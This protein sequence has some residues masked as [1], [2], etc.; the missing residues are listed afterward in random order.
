MYKVNTGLLEDLHISH[1]Q[2][3][4]QRLILRS[5]LK[6]FFKPGTTRLHSIMSIIL[7]R[8]CSIIKLFSVAMEILNSRLK[9]NGY[10]VWYVLLMI[11]WVFNKTESAYIGSSTGL[12][13]LNFHQKCDIS[14]TKLCLRAVCL[15]RVIYENIHYT[16]IIPQKVTTQL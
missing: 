13:G 4:W 16:L 14:L 1:N 8:I 6:G 15:Y 3:P 2:I 12:H 10:S 11:F 7:W 5:R 9:Y